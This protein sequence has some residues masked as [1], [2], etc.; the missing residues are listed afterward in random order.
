MVG[1]GFGWSRVPNPSASRYSDVSRINNAIRFRISKN[2]LIYANVSKQTIYNRSRHKFITSRG[3]WYQYPRFTTYNA[4]IS[5]VWKPIIYLFMRYL[6]LQERIWLQI[7]KIRHYLRYLES[8]FYRQFRV[9]QNTKCV[10]NNI[11]KVSFD[12]SSLI[13]SISDDAL[14]IDAI[15]L[16]HTLYLF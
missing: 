10:P 1:V 4:Q 5:E 13:M 14:K 15:Y 7:L 11:L 3:L 6:T 16:P 2:I 12:M 9:V 8:E